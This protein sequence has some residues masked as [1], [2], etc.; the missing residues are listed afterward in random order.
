MPLNIIRATGSIKTDSGWK[1]NLSRIAEKHPNTPLGRSVN[2]RT[3]K[4]IK[5]R[6][7]LKKHKLI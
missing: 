1:E 4:E 2:K 7:V 5:T 6:E 3:S